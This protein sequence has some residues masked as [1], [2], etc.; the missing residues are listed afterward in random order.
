MHRSQCRNIVN[1]FHDQKMHAL[2][3]D[4]S[5]RQW[6]TLQTALERGR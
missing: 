6:S 5:S 2:V 3:V 1:G 4:D